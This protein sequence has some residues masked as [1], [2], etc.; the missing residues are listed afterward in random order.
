[1][2]EKDNLDIDEEMAKSLQRLVE[3]ET[4]VA[5]ASIGNAVEENKAYKNDAQY[6][7]LGNTTEI[8]INLG[9]T[10]FVDT[11]LINAKVASMAVHEDINDDV[12][13][14]VAGSNNI[15]SSNVV[16]N[17]NQS[18]MSNNVTSN[19]RNNNQAYINNN[20]SYIR[21]NA[22][23]TYQNTHKNVPESNH[24]KEDANPTTGLSKR[25]KI[26]IASIGGVVAVSLIIGIIMIVVQNKNKSSYNYN[27]DRGMAF[28]N[29]NNYV[30]AI[31]YLEIAFHSTEGKKNLDMMYVLSEAYKK[32][33]NNDKA[34][35]V[36]E[37][38]L[39]YNKF[40]E[41]TLSLLLQLCY[42][43]KKGEKI[44]EMVEEYKDS[45]VKN[46]LN[47][48]IVAI[49]T[50]SE[51][52]G[53]FEDS[54]ELNLLAQDGCIIYYTI[55]GSTPTKNSIQFTK[56]IKVE[57][58]TVTVKAIAVND[59]GVKS[60]VGEFKFTIDLK[61]PE[62]PILDIED[63]K[64][65][66]GTKIRI[67]NL[68]EGD[69]AYYTVDGTTP[70]ASSSPYNDGIELKEGNYVLSVIVI[71]KHNLS[72]TVTRKNITVKDETEYTYNQALGF[73]KKRMQELNIIESNG[74]FSVGG[75]TADFV[76][77]TKQ[78]ISGIPMY[79][80]R[81]DRK[82]AGS[83]KVEGYYG[84]GVSD[85]QCYKVTDSDGLLSA[86]VY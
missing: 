59:I 64:V 12:D 29:E 53:N 77:Q 38:A 19:N 34:I 30:D 8:D 55:D 36:L 10:R 56:P 27:Y 73:L 74:K 1:M 63:S 24:K 72:S 6:N 78:E 31:K 16:S 46:V 20:Q 85:G 11:N 43:N 44:N 61:A 13:N 62:A 9:A 65:K 82:S 49:P 3:E 79:Y 54:V 25:N 70:T 18:Y 68:A 26:I 86:V 23:S 17:N 81:L 83:S 47:E 48:Y 80:I 14:N 45:K 35:E 2:E 51:T 39:A 32:T 28:Y 37:S 60:D 4:N 7:E 40:D 75:E 57:K 67:K 33:G 41:R 58:D 52:P 66:I 50:P 21:D 84:V 15:T 71:N 22:S 5:K 69:K 42:D 76:Y